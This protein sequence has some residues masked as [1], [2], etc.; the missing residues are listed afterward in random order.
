[1]GCHV[2]LFVEFY[3]RTYVLLFQVHVRSITYIFLSILY[4]SDLF[5]RFLTFY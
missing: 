5:F 2:I 1:M 3:N 4:D